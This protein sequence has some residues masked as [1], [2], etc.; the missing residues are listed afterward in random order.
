MNWKKHL[1]KLEHSKDYKLAVELIQNVIKDNPNDI[2]AYIRAI[3]LLHNILVEEDYPES[4]HDFLAS[5]LKSYFDISYRKFSDNT[6][7]LFF[8]GKILYIEEWYFGLNDDVK[9][10]EQSL[11]FQMQKKAHEM[12]KG[13]ALYEWAYRFSLGDKLAA[14]LAEQILL[15]DKATLEWLKSKGFPG[16]YVLETLEQSQEQQ[17]T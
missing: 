17:S 12:V 4:E 16:E 6:E 15:H 2:E 11:A 13:N 1:I 8:V 3:Y 9:P 5:L 7:Y 10:I 14:Y